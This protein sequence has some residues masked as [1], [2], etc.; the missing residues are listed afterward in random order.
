MIELSNNG[1]CVLPESVNLNEFQ[2]RD[3]NIVC[4]APHPDDDALGV[5]GSLKI[6]ADSEDNVFTV[7]VTSGSGSPTMGGRRSPASLAT[8]RQEEAVKS[9]RVYGGLAGIF[10]NFESAD[11]TKKRMEE[12]TQDIFRVLIALKPARIYVPSPFEKH[13]THIA[14]LQRTLEAI[15]K[16]PDFTP[17]LRGFGVWSDIF[18]AQNEL[19]IV[20][21]TDVIDTKRRACR[22]HESQFKSTARD[23]AMVGYNHYVAAY[24][25]PYVPVVGAR[26]SEKQLIMDEIASRPELEINVYAR[27][28]ALKH[29]HDLYQ[30]YNN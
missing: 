3:N 19:E 16:V 15:Y 26:Y 21:I 23:A 10:L 6:H 8:L 25:D 17:E 18:A 22:A 20:D 27:N 7:F 4:I 29:L 14:C 9:M 2:G 1:A 5:G 28:L 13:L 24:N 30:S 11:V 12:V